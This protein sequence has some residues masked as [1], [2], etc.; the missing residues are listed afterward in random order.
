[1]LLYFV[2]CRDYK[3]VMMTIAAE[4]N[5]YI[6]QKIPPFSIQTYLYWSE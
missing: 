3:E 6:N 2:Y 4:D 5:G 1:M